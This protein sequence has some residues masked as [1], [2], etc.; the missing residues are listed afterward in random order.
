MRLLRI[1]FFVSIYYLTSL[2]CINGQSFFVKIPS[3]SIVNVEY[4]SDSVRIISANNNILYL[5]S[6]G[7]P[8]PRPSSISKTRLNHLEITLE[9]GGVLVA[10]HS[11]YEHLFSGKSIRHI[12]NNYVASYDGL[13]KNGRK[14][15]ALTY[16]NG[17]IRE[18]GDSILVAWDGFTVF[19][20]DSIYDFTSYDTIGTI[21][22]GKRLGFTRDAIAWGNNIFLLTTRGI[23]KYN[24][25]SKDVQTVYKEPNDRIQLWSNEIGVNGQRQSLIVGL[26]SGRYRI[27]EDGTYTKIE[28]LTTTFTYFNHKQGILLFPDRIKDYTKQLEMIVA[29]NYHNVFKVGEVYFGASDYGLF[30]YADREDP[31][32]LNAVEYNARSFRISKDTVYLGSISGLYKYPFE[33]L[34]HA[35][36]SQSEDETEEVSPTLLGFIVLGILILIG[37]IVLLVTINSRIDGAVK[38]RIPQ[39]VTKSVLLEY[40]SLNIK[41]V[42]I[43]ALCHEFDLNQK[44]LYSFFP[45]SSPG[46]TIK[47]LRL[48]KAKQL[49]DEGKSSDIIASETGYSKKYLT[50]TI[51]PQLKNNGNRRK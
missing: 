34:L 16:S 8:T 41:D 13:F 27:F 29:N 49:Y 25:V 46:A 42:S 9:K 14:F 15:S 6:S 51:L 31:V 7:L 18:V 10:T 32:Q 24:A 36:K 47:Q 35:I 44:E 23:F 38:S 28:D 2:Q 50:Q 22:N 11:T 43:A 20:K 12:G 3:D 4:L 33:Y 39:E 19:H 26:G 5:D 1:F 37:F 48:Y 17:T 21:I 45:E 30:A 40:I